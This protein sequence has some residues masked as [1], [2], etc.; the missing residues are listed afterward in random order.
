MVSV[1]FITEKAMG[2]YYLCWY[3]KIQFT[4]KPLD[5]Q[6]KEKFSESDD[7]LK[8][9]SRYIVES[10]HI[11][12]DLLQKEMSSEEPQISLLMAH[13]EDQLMGAEMLKLVIMELIEL[14]KDK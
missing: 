2:N 10:H 11:H 7:K 4:W 8:E 5:L 14:H 3:G 13:A 12:A 9:G 6:N 1:E